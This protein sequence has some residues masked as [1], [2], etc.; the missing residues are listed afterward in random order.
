MVGFGQETDAPI[1]RPSRHPWARDHDPLASRPDRIN[2]LS[3]RVLLEIC[4][5]TWAILAAPFRAM[6][7][8]CLAEELIERA[9][10]AFG[11]LIVAV[12]HA[13]SQVVPRHVDRRI[14]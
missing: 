12:A 6:R 1:E 8:G 3:L 14:L 5:Q 10:G 9:L 7:S 11:R 2:G 4:S 13:L